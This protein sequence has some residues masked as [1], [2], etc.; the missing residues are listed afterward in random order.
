MELESQVA[1]IQL[2]GT[3]EARSYVYVLAEKAEGQDAEL[4]L[5][6][7]LPL[8]NPQ[9][10][11]TCEQICEAA[12]A[13][14]RRAY[15]R[16]SGD[17][18]FELAVS[19]VNDELS[20]L[21]ATGQ[22][23]WVEKLSAVLAAKHGSELQLSTCGKVA[24][25]LVRSGELSDISCSAGKTQPLKAFENVST[26]KLALGDAF[27]LSTT[28]L[29]NYVSLDRLLELLRGDFLGAAQ[30]AMQILR[31]TAGPDVSFGT[32]MALQVEA[33]SAPEAEIDLEA[34]ADEHRGPGFFTKLATRAWQWGAS[35]A[36]SEQARR[37]PSWLRPSF[38][39]PTLETLA[40]LPG[41]IGSG[42]KSAVKAAA[43]GVKQTREFGVE[44]VRGYSPHKKLLAASVLVLVVA[45]GVN[46]WATARYRRVSESRARLTEQL[47][48]A[49]SLADNAESALIYRNTEDARDFFR[50]ALEAIPS[51][52]SLSG[53]QRAA[54][55]QLRSRLEQLR[56][57]VDKR[58]TVEPQN[59][60]SLGRGTR[61]LKLGRYLAVQSGSTIVSYDTTT[62]LIQD[63][64]L[65]VSEQ[66]TDAAEQKG[67]VA[68]GYADGKLW[69]WDF[70]KRILS[71]AFTQSVPKAEG[72]G[73]IEYYPTN[74]RSYLLDKQAG[75][76][77]SFLITEK[78][79]AKPVV[80][81]ATPDLATAQDFAI[82]GS[83]YVLFPGGSVSKYN[84]G[85]PAEFHQ[86]TLL[87]PTSGEG[88]IDTQVGYR[89]IYVL[90]PGN[91]RVLVISKKGEL[92]GTVG[93]QS[94]GKLTDLSVD[95][96]NKVMYLLSDGSLLKVPLPI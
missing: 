10:A 75:R 46:V 6:C 15:R 22:A 56:E 2:G 92:V 59:L 86:P 24:A 63:G 94:F 36:T 16:A 60:G 58:L 26:G 68:A 55:E 30:S 11:E 62:G 4:Y 69:G 53:E 41:K 72:F 61:L 57:K 51:D 28:Q 1:K 31:E 70:A 39:L 38:K 76:I 85:K 29:L 19:S 67:S 7:E 89:N 82:D 78:S 5:I 44:H 49:A 54:A 12:G 52:G 77:V 50:R 9:A 43:S 18:A 23:H 87:S 48:A 64:A 65:V 83:I 3:R 42:T 95:E 14:L 80:S 93:H 96:P 8:L 90:D 21:A 45:A 84:A 27:V 33:G 34:Y 40:K 37:A 20:R 74:S 25:Y 17:E 91:R 66:F 32:V 88:R 35:F 47:G 73:G 79:V 13:A 81:L 71:P